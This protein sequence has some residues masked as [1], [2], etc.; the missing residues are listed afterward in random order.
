MT[1]YGPAHDEQ[2]GA[3]PEPDP[4]PLRRS[5][6]YECAFRVAEDGVLTQLP[7][8]LAAVQPLRL[9]LPEIRRAYGCV[10]RARNAADGSWGLSL[11]GEV[12]YEHA[13]QASD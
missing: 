2:S 13:S 6:A 8:N 1:L 7:E 9:E 3:E 5:I 12:P 10:F 4:L 11:M